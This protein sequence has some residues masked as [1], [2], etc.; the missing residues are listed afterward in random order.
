MTLQELYQEIGGGYQGI[1]E[2]FGTEERVRKFVLLFLKDN[3]F[4]LYLDALQRQDANEAFRA[5]HTLKGVCLNLSFDSLYQSVHVSTEA[6]RKGDLAAGERLLPEL[7]GRYQQHI[8]AIRN[9]E[10]NSHA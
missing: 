6:L 3:S 10:R 7:T 1:L 4:A 9:Y 8:T 2:R 5:I